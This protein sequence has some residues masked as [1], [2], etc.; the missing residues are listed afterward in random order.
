MISLQSREAVQV[1]DLTA[2]NQGQAAVPGVRGWSILC[3]FNRR[4]VYL[5]KLD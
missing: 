2:D 3:L 1:L 5:E 4:K